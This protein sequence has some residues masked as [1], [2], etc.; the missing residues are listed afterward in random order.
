MSGTSIFKAPE[1]LERKPHD[2]QADI[3]SLGMN[4][5]YHLYFEYPF[6]IKETDNETNFE[7]LLKKKIDSNDIY[8]K[9]ND[10]VSDEAWEFLEA[11][12]EKDPNKRITVED[13]LKL[14]WFL[15]IDDQMHA[16]SNVI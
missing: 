7:S 8:K 15:L 4:I 1:V 13:A 14:K 10:G 3:W 6:N 11:V 16:Y 2:Y 12:L 9:E 5:F